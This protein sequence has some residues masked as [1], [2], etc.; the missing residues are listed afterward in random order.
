MPA[1]IEFKADELIY[2]IEDSKT[3]FLISEKN[4]NAA[5]DLGAEVN[6]VEPNELR[7]GKE[8][9]TDA[10]N[11]DFNGIFLAIVRIR[12]QESQKELC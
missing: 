11:C 4:R 10:D 7:E 12:Q 5:I 1:N 9:K 3:K 8:L 6:R 2:F